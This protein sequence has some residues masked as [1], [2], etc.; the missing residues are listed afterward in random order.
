M[1]EVEAPVD[2][3][4]NNTASG[5]FFVGRATLIGVEDGIGGNLGVVGG[6]DGFDVR[7]EVG[8]PGGDFGDFGGGADINQIGASGANSDD[9]AELSDEADARRQ[10][11]GVTEAEYG[12]DFVI[13]VAVFEHL[14]KVWT[15]GGT[16]P[17]D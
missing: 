1:S 13:A 4:D 10:G 11:G 3:A 16:T 12:G 7:A 6:F 17:V 14:P 2:Q 9:L 8:V 5:G 15:H